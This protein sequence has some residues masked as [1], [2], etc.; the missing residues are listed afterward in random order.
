MIPP[1]CAC[2]NTAYHMPKLLEH[3]SGGLDED[4]RPLPLH[5]LTQMQDQVESLMADSLVS[6]VSAFMLKVLALAELGSRD[7]A[8]AADPEEV[9]RRFGAV[10]LPSGAHRAWGR[11]QWARITARAKA[12]ASELHERH[13]AA[14]KGPDGKLLPWVHGK[15]LDLAKAEARDALPRELSDVP[16]AFVDVAL[17]LAKAKLPSWYTELT[18]G[19]LVAREGLATWCKTIAAT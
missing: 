15:A 19:Q 12:L 6:D 8:A 16:N 4:G 17:Q 1:P 13:P 14:A 11:E 18:A 7:A 3:L 9:A 5:S 2:P 10:V